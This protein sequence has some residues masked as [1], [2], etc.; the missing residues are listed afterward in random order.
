[1]RTSPTSVYPPSDL[2]AKFRRLAVA[3]WRSTSSLIAEAVQLCGRQEAA[4]SAILR[5]LDQLEARIDRTLRDG[6]EIKEIVLYF[7]RVWLEHNPPV[8]E[9]LE[10][11]ADRQRP[12]AV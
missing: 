3:H 2:S 6:A 8:D 9:D 12:A 10:E 7:V 1:M 4:H 11:S 5:R